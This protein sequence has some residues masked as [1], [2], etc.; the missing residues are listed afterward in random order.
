MQRILGA[1]IDAMILV[2]PVHALSRTP[3]TVV[4]TG[5]RTRRYVSRMSPGGSSAPGNPPAL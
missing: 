4:A 5:A 2:I 3:A 1:L